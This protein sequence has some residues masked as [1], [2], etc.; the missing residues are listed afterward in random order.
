MEY[1]VEVE[2]YRMAFVRATMPLM[3]FDLDTGA[4]VE[5]NSAADQAYGYR[6]NEWNAVS[7]FQIYDASGTRP[8]RQDCVTLPRRSP[9]RPL[10]PNTGAA[11]AVS[12]GPRPR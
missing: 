10:S 8:W 3:V 9:G 6:A 4:C 7:L 5:A 2:P 11:T 12:S 1:R